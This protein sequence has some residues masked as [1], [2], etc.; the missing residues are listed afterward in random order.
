MKTLF[1]HLDDFVAVILVVGCLILKALGYDAD[2]MNILYL[3]AAYAFG[4]G[5]Q[6]VSSR[7]NGK[8]P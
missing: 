7:I 1:T 8:Q 5:G 4:K 2:I 3:G 6:I